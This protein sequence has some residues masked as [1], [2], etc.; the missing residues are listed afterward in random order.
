MPASRL[1]PQSGN[2]WNLAHFLAFL[3]P[4]FVFFSAVEVGDRT[5]RLSLPTGLRS[6]PLRLLNQLQLAPGLH[7]KNCLKWVF[8]TSPNVNMTLICLLYLESGAVQSTALDPLSPCHCCEWWG[9]RFKGGG[10]G[11]RTLLCPYSQSSVIILS[12]SPCEYFLREDERSNILFLAYTSN[13]VFSRFTISAFKND[14]R[15]SFLVEKN[16]TFAKNSTKSVTSSH[17]Q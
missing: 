15:N 5:H 14:S 6:L 10:G 8:P 11:E 3:R 7:V 13:S 1:A 2:F 17:K 9:Y 4:F 16:P 12:S